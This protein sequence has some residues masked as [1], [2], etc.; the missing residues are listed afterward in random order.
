MSDLRGDV[1][2][3]PS[4]Q[5]PSSIEDESTPEDNLKARPIEPPKELS[6]HLAVPR[7]PH[8]V[9]VSDRVPQRQR[10]LEDLFEAAACAVGAGL[11]LLLGMYA[12]ST[13]QGVEEDVRAAFDSVIRQILFLPLSVLEGLFVIAV[14]VAIIV[15]LAV[16]GNFTTIVHTVLTAVASALIGWGYLLALPYLPER[17]S[18]ALQIS[19]PTGELSSVN[20]VMMVIIAMVTVAGTAE[21]SRA[22]RLSWWGI[23]LLMF[24]TLIRGTTTLP[25]VFLTVL[26]GRFLGCIARWIA[27]FND[28]RAMPADLVDACLDINLSPER[29]VRCDVSTDAVP[30]ETWVVTEGDK[31]PDYRRGQIHPPLMTGS[32]DTAE[33]AFEVNPQLVQ[34]ADRTYQVWDANGS[35]LDLHVL[36]PATGITSMLGDLW[37]NFRLKGTSRWITPSIKAGAERAMLTSASAAVAGVRTPKPVGL[38]EAGSSVAVFWETLPPVMGLLSLR[39][40]QIEISDNVLDQAWNQ[41]H[42]AHLRS[43]SHRNLG[44]DSVQVDDSMK[45]WIV[46]W[47]Q[48]DVG[49]TDMSRRIDCAQMLVLQSLATDPDRALAAALRQIGMAELLAT[50]LVLQ[51]AV[52]PSNLR[53]SAR[54]S[55]VLNVLRDRLSEIAPTVDAP[56]PIKLERFSPRTVVMAVLG[57]AALVAIFGGLNFEAVVQAVRGANPWWIL[58][59]FLLGCVPWVGS[60]ISLVAFSPT[61]IKL[62]YATAAQ[63]AASLVTLVAP[64]G[65][66]PAAL[67][68]RFLSKQ[69]IPTPVA[70]A[71]VTLIQVSQFLTSVILLFTVVIGTGASVNLPIPMASIVWGAAAI[72]TVVVAV[73]SIPPLRKWLWKKLKPSWDQAYPQFLW[74]LGH[75]KELGIAF[76]GNMLQSVGYIASFGAALAAF[77]YSLNPMTLAITFLLSSTVGSIIPTPGGIGPVEAA[78]TGG[79]QVAGVPAAVALSTAVVFRLVTFYGRIPLGW[80]ALKWMEKRNLL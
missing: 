57:V 66:G 11:V 48:G 80:L 51:S 42:S 30:L 77:G 10:R 5:V 56:P 40:H 25:G 16:R 15:H 53:E 27:G 39:E 62:A 72:A 54:K 21:T 36:D 43:I 8:S 60:A 78:L 73:L 1:S 24:F 33:D 32:L 74:I 46:D 38:A 26:L 50:G 7:L 41:L 52:L 35:R 44:A 22:F 3:G 20:V 76:I 64:A 13:T 70:V 37:A 6:D 9:Y 19:T 68:L 45:V 67:N 59:S 23:W 69:Q 31:H 28:G 29:I 12:Q 63:M 71:T 75:P 2:D 61:R 58:G 17:V 55:K 47:T 4:S 18:E 14:P 34:D 65:L 49:A 79:L